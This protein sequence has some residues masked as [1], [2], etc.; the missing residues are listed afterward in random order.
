MHIYD[1]TRKN[2]NKILETFMKERDFFRFHYGLLSYTLPLQ[3]VI[4]ERQNR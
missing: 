2:R 3:V 1:T 4:F